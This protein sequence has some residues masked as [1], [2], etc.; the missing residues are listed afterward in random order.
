MNARC[1]VHALSETE[2]ILLYVTEG[3]ISVGYLNGTTLTVW[4][5]RFMNPTVVY[6]DS[7]DDHIVNLNYSAALK[8]GTSVFVYMSREAGSVIGVE[9]KSDGKW[10]D[11][12]EAVPS[13]L[14]QFKIANA[15]VAP[16]GVVHYVRPVPARG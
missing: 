12:F 11:T 2:Y 15:F 7:S 6:L 3:G 16:N 10:S 9:R 1:A 8:F 5:R 4:P 14:S 13:D